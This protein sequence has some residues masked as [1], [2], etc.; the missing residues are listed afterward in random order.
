MRPRHLAV[1]RLGWRTVV[2]NSNKAAKGNMGIWCISFLFGS[3][4]SPT[5]ASAL[6]QGFPLDGLATGQHDASICKTSSGSAA[7][8]GLVHAGPRLP[9]LSRRRTTTTTATT[10]GVYQGA[11]GC[12]VR[13]SCRML[14]AVGR[15]VQSYALCPYTM[16][17]A[18]R[19]D[20]QVLLQLAWYRGANRSATTSGYN[21]WFQQ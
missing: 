21:K 1:Q 8:G 5:L 19:G 13:C 2:H 15:P 17:R 4:R 20:D 9:S 6:P 10:G 12:E 14:E 11:L 16:P 7:L 18:P 3:L